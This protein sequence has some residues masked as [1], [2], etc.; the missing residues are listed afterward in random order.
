LIT[1]EDLLTGKTIDR[2]P[3]Q[4]STTFKKAPKAA[5]KG[6]ERKRS[7]LTPRSRTTTSRSERRP[8]HV[9]AENR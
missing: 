5:A 2:P 8:V 4:T 3:I 6:A 7:I 9:P 1:V